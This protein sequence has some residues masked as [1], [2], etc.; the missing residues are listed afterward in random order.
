MDEPSIQS[1]LTHLKQAGIVAILR[2]QNRNRMIERGIALCEMG[3]KAIEVTLDSP[4][5]L[6]IISTLREKLPES[7]MV[8]VGTLTDLNSIDDCTHAG[9]VFALSPTHPEGM[10]QHC[11]AANLLAIPGVSNMHELQEAISSGTRIA[12]LFPST[13]WD[14]EQIPKQTIPWMPVGG[15]DSQNIWQWLDA[16][17]WCVGMGA[18]LCGSDL[19][20]DDQYNT[21][22]ADSEEQVARGIFK[23][24]QRR[25]NDA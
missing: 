10:I 2:G 24:L 4:D 7:V 6:E 19:S 14:S 16:G 11:H 13:E 12:K 25:R 3:C 21:S 23:E 1:I 9:A 8:G 17:A 15:V 20:D 18:N 5:A 22:W